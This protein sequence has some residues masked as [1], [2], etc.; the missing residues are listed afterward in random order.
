MDAVIAVI[1]VKFQG[2][3][4]SHSCYQCLFPWPGMQSLLI[5]MSVPNARNIVI[6]VVNVKSHS[7]DAVSIPKVCDVVITVI[8]VSTF[9][10]VWSYLLSVSIPKA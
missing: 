1:Y 6:A 7:L 8:S 2:F 10:E 4:C 9:H 5:P 3:E